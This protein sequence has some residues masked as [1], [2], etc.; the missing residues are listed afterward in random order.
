ML[1]NAAKTPITAKAG[2]AEMRHMVLGEHLRRAAVR[3]KD[4]GADDLGGITVAHAKQLRWR[5][6]QPDDRGEDH[7]DDH[8]CCSRNDP[9]DHVCAPSM[10][11]TLDEPRHDFPQVPEKFSA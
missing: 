3:K 9:S 1:K 11:T 5:N 2:M 6:K 4:I 8:Q 7:R 10:P